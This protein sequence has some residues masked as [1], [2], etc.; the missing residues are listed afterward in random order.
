MKEGVTEDVFNAVEPGQF[1]GNLH[2]ALIFKIPKLSINMKSDQNSDLL[3]LGHQ[4]N[5]S[6]IIHGKTASQIYMCI[7]HPAVFRNFTG[8]NFC[9]ISYLE[10]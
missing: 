6:N 1:H 8:H 2:F 5:I 10:S 9:G 4:L 7:F 3:H